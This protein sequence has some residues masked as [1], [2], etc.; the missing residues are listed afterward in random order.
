MKKTSKEQKHCMDIINLHLGVDIRSKSRDQ[1]VVAGRY[2]YVKIM[3]DMGDKCT[4]LGRSIGVHHASI[5]HYRKKFDDYYNH[6]AVLK[7]K[8][9]EVLNAFN[10][11]YDPMLLLTTCEL[12]REIIKLREK[13][14]S[15]T[16]KEAQHAED[17]A[18]RKFTLLHNLID[19]R[20]TEDNEEEMYIKL[21]AYFNG[22]SN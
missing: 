10:E 15:L 2:I 18:N 21:R 9:N 6:S 17:K 19:E 1:E 7:R 12:Q 11:K 13:N 4:H 8:Y 3:S 5:L 20:A 22:I 16:L 14:V